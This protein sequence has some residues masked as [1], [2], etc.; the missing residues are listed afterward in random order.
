MKKRSIAN[1]AKEV[2]NAERKPAQIF[3]TYEKRRV[4]RR[5]TLEENEAKVIYTLL[6]INTPGDLKIT[7]KIKILY[8][9]KY[10]HTYDVV[11]T[12]MQENH[13]IFQ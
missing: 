12:E 5:P 4:G 7:E 11:F 9:E 10:R 6:E 2:E 3:S 1:I 13:E 8:I